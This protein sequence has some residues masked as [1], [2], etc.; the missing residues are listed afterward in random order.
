MQV[1]IFF[2]F[3]FENLK[4]LEKKNIFLIQK[5][6]MILGENDTYGEKQSRRNSS[7]QNLLTVPTAVKGCCVF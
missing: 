1:Y 2:S 4:S 5:L 3:F 7:N 6:N